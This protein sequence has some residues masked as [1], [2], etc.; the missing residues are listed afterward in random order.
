[1]A[2]LEQV[3]QRE[4]AWIAACDGVDALIEK[5]GDYRED[6]RVAE[7][8]GHMLMRM[9]AGDLIELAQSQVVRLRAGGMRKS[10]ARSTPEAPPPAVPTVRPAE[11]ARQPTVVRAPARRTNDGAARR[12]QDRRDSALRVKT[13][14]ALAEAERARA[15]ARLAEAEAAKIEAQTALLRARTEASMRPAVEPAPAKRTASPPPSPV[16]PAPRGPGVAPATSVARKTIAARPPAPAPR[17]ATPSQKA[18]TP[19]DDG[20]TEADRLAL[21]SVGH[22]PPTPLNH[23]GAFWSKHDDWPRDWTLTGGD[24]GRFRGEVNLTRA[25]FAARGGQVHRRAARAGRAGGGARGNPHGVRERGGP[26]A[27]RPC[28]RRVHRGRPRADASRTA[29][30]AAGDGGPPRR[31]AGHHLEGRGQGRGGGGTGTAGGDGAAGG[32]RRRGTRFGDSG[33][34][35]VISRKRCRRFHGI[36]QNI[37][38]RGSQRTVG[39]VTSG[40]PE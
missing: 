25:V 40:C 35:P 28:P 14:A 2:T 10:E 21:A 22:W 19:R 16:R 4:K 33:I 23:R 32:G 11:V 27:A 8:D 7:R 20:Y 39:S 30:L 36:M 1:M 17:P 5:I 37:P 29:T 31:G 18:T 26:R 24:L 38:E 15:A 3:F 9:R 13:E 6:V 12:E 34:M